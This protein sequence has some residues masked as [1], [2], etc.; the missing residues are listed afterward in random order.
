MPKIASDLKTIFVGRSESYYNRSSQR[1]CLV[2]NVFLQKVAGLGPAVLFKKW[3]LPRCFPMND[4]TLELSLVLTWNTKTFCIYKVICW[5]L[6]WWKICEVLQKW[7]K[8]NVALYYLYFV[9]SSLVNV[10]LFS[11]YYFILWRTM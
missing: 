7:N 1:R 4:A 2:E 11:K 8:R 10:T 9:S 5:T 3:L 6:F